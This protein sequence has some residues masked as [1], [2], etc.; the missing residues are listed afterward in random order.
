MSSLIQVCES[1]LRV[2]LSS[3]CAFGSIIYLKPLSQVSILLPAKGTSWSASKKCYYYL[4]KSIPSLDI[5]FS[6]VPSLRFPIFH[7]VYLSQKKRTF[8]VWDLQ[9]PWEI[10]FKLWIKYQWNSIPSPTSLSSWS[11]TVLH[12]PTKSYNPSARELTQAY[13]C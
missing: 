5:S 9:I 11:A 8:S 4:L 6:L 10:A 2:H 1:V 7:Y 12:I 13:L 3:W